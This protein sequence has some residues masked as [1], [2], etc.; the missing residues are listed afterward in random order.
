MEKNHFNYGLCV[1]TVADVVI[2]EQI[3]VIAEV[4]I[5]IDLNAHWCSEQ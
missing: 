3:N 1:D 4:F 5:F 2:I